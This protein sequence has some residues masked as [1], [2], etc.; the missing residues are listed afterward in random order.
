MS[1]TLPTFNLLFSAKANYNFAGAG[2]PPG[3][4]ILVGTPCNLAYSRRIHGA[5][6]ANLDGMYLLF[7]AGVALKGKDSYAVK[8]GDA[9][10]VPQGSGRWYTVNYVDRVGAGFSNE[11]QSA[12]LFH[13]FMAYPTT[14]YLWPAP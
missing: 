13:P 8:N 14:T 2:A 11:H 9:V 6:G 12:Q 3:P 10:E 1:Y 5:I 4:Y 7:A